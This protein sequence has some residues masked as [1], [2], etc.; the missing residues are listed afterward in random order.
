MKTLKLVK[1]LD[2]C[3]CTIACMSMITGIPYFE[4]RSR[5]H[6][7]CSE[8]VQDGIINHEKI[9]LS[10]VEE[11]AILERIFEIPCRFIKFLSLNELRKHCILTICDLKGRGY[12]SVV[13]DAKTRSILD[14][15]NG[16]EIKGAYLNEYNVKCCIEIQ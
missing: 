8:E 14:P 5:L 6:L 12:H 9:G 13:F 10:C 2:E 16:K 1:Q 4:M 15:W 11:Q 7:E 3:G